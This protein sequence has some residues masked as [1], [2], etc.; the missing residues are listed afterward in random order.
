M[1]ASD[2]RVSEAL[3]LSDPDKYAGSVDMA[4]PEPTTTDA[5]EPTGQDTSTKEPGSEVRPCLS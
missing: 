1:G 5:G 2:H 3:Y 4:D